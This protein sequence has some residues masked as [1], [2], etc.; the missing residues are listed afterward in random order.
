MSAF[1]TRPENFHENKFIKTDLFLWWNFFKKA[2]YLGC[3]MAM[4][5]NFCSYP[6]LQWKRAKNWAERLKNKKKYSLQRK[7]A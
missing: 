5:K 3:G 4:A 6:S 7:R 1:C 2:E